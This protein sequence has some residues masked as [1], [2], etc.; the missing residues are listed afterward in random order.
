MKY[1]GKLITASILIAALGIFMLGA[2]V[3]WSTSSRMLNKYQMSAQSQE[4]RQEACES[5][6]AASAH[7]E[8]CSKVDDPINCVQFPRKYVYDVSAYRL[9]YRDC[10]E[11]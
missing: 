4:K 10:L 7:L 2:S 8:R 9:R 11:R 6:A 3:F 5:S 1:R